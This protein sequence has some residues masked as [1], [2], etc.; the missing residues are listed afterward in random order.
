MVN[1]SQLRVVRTKPRVFIVSDISNEPDDAESLV[2]YL[3]YSN[4]FD[5]RGLVAFHPEDMQ[6]IV[7]AY[8]QVV[9]NLNRH[10]HPDNQYSPGDYFLGLIKSGP[11]MFGKEALDPSVELSEGSQLLIDRLEESTDPLWVLCW[12][13]TNVIAQALQAAQQSMSVED[14]KNFRSKLRIY[15]ISDQDDTGV[16]IRANYPDIF[17]MNSI[18]GWNQYGLALWTGI[19]GDKYYGFDKGGPDFTKVSADWIR[20]HIQIGPLGQAYPDFMFIPEGDTPTFLYL[21]QNGL[22]SPEHPDWGSWGGRYLAT[23]PSAAV[24]HYNDAT[25]MVVGQNGE[26]FLSNHATIWRW[27]DAFQNDFAARIQ[28][29]LHDDISKANHAPIAIVNGSTPGPEPVFLEAEAG[30]SIDLDALESFDPDGD[31]LTFRWFHYKDV[32][33]SQWNVDAEVVTVEFVDLE[34]AKPGRRVRAVLPPPEKC[35]VDMFTGKAQIKGQVMHF[36]LE[37]S[38]SG[39]PSMTTY[40]RVVVQTTNKE[41]KG[42][43]KAVESI[44]QVHTLE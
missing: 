11:P 44:A 23:D 4:E 6:K 40:K 17:Y 33:A 16:W 2:R 37:L 18:H 41:L 10:A 26:K 27:R 36:V 31:E 42:G 24:R 43:R 19:S 35:A 9:D 13:G 12:G 39:T 29:S 20:E 3:L 5:T 1:Q 7:T 25:D 8:S 30:T 22:G 14:H 32:T 38:D 15:A 21:I 28:W 34:P